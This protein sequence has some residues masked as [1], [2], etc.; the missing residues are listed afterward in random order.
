MQIAYPFHIDPHGL[1]MSTGEDTH[2]RD[3]IEQVLFTAPGERVN[4][5]GFG[6]ALLRMVFASADTEQLAALQGLVQGSLQQWLRDLIKVERVSVDS[7]ES[8]LT[9]FVQY[10]VLQT[11]QRQ[12]ARFVR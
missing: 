3:L 8:T 12:S 5:P 11:Q 1:L 9:V 2:I 10:V 4:R 6:C 7:Q